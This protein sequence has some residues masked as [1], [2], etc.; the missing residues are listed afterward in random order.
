MLAAEDFALLVLDLREL[1]AFRVVALRDPFP[2]VEERLECKRG[3][4]ILNPEVLG[5]LVIHPVFDR[6][7]HRPGRRR[8]RQFSH[9]VGGPTER[10]QWVA[11]LKPFQRST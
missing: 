8:K 3:S 1:A 10:Q 5:I 6:A 11:Q 7:L 2:V 4:G 9:I